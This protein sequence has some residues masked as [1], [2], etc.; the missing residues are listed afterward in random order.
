[1]EKKQKGVGESLND[2]EFKNEPVKDF[3]YFLWDL[4]KTGVIVFLVAF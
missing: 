3:F 1:M 2:M 4:F